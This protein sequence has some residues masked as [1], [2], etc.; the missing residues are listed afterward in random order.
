MG[1]HD[2]WAR[3]SPFDPLGESM[4]LFPLAVQWWINWLIV[5]GL[6]SILFVWKYVGARWVL[7]AYVVNHSVALGTGW[8]FGQ[9]ML[10]NGLVSVTHVVFWTPAVYVLAVGLK[11][12]S[13]L[14]IYNTWH[15]VAL[16]TMIIS[17]FFDYRD[18][19]VFLFLNPNVL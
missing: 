12:M 2:A 11:K 14:T 8:I 7:G 5:I 3:P 4:T 13:A 19:F 16:L 18:S 10:T 17:L 9:D 15:A 1:M 6:S